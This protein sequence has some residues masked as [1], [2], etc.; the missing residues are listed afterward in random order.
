M[1]NTSLINAAAMLVRGNLYTMFADC[2]VNKLIV[3]RAKF[4]QTLLNYMVSV[5][6]FDECYHV[7][8]KCCNHCLYLFIVLAPFYW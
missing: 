1:I 4:M 6:I 3:L 7:G 2:V 5:Q 8:F